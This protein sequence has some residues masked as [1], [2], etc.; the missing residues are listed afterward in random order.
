MKDYEVVVDWCVTIRGS[1]R[2]SMPAHSEEEAIEI[3]VDDLEP[4]DFNNYTKIISWDHDAYVIKK[5]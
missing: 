4:I 1:K 3:V 5:E 2:V